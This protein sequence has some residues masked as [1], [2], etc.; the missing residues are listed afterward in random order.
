MSGCG[1]C[2]GGCEGCSGCS[3]C[4]GALTLHPGEVKILELLAQFPFLPKRCC[5]PM[6]R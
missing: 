3:G 5:Q 1:N 4:G 6:L 2:S